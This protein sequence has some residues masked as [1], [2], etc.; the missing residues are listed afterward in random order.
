MREPTKTAVT[1]HKS[2]VEIDYIKMPNVNAVAAQNER[3]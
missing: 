3:K 2:S 1:I